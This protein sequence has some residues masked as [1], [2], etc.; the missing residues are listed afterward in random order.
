DIQPVARA[1][2]RPGREIRNG[3]DAAALPDR[4]GYTL[5]AAEGMLPSFVQK[6]PWFAGFCAVMTNV[7]DIAAMGGRA[8]AIVDVLFASEDDAHTRA[9]LE[10]LAAGADTFGVPVVGGHTSRGEGSAHLSAAI[11]GHARRL[12]TSFDARPGD[13]VIACIDLRG[14]Y[15]GES[16]HF[17]AVSGA[18]IAQVRAQLEL[19]PQL[20]EAELV[21]AGKDISNAGLV[22]SLLM[23]LETSGCGAR[24][25]LAAV[26]SPVGTRA[27]PARWLQAFPSYGYLL[28]ARARDAV[29][30]IARAGAVGV[31]AAAIAELQAGSAL[32]ISYHG[33][34]ER[35]WDHAQEPLLGFAAPAKRERSHA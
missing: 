29:E 16:C 24:L 6:E 11:V 7:S 22:G 34:I 32:D 2:A 10:G 20:A 18:P 25:D 26:P 21:H 35:Y 3:D 13:V 31:H 27:A 5:I 33:A 12:I 19:L 1:L 4:D 23:L 28:T 15:R 8:R 14:Q 30:V 9:V 17:D